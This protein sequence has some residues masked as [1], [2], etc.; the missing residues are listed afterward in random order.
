MS[1]GKP[2]SRDWRAQP[3]AQSL[4]AREWRGAK[5]E[6]A[7]RFSRKFKLR[8]VGL[9]LVTLVAVIVYLLAPAADRVPSVQI[10]TFGIGAYGGRAN[11]QGNMPVNP[12]GE[13]DARAFGVLN[14]LDPKQFPSVR[15]GDNALNGAQFL[16][17]LQKE[18]DAPELIDQHLLVFCTLH[19]L[20][21]T[22]GDVELFA[23][24]AT[25]DSPST[26]SGT[27]VPLKEL[28][29]RLQSSRARRVLLVLDAAR[30]EA[31]WRLG[32]LNNDIAAGGGRLAS[33]KSKSRRSHGG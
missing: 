12:F 1:A 3:P 18:A 25:P 29:T 10:V 28:V 23:I 31:H 4:Y 11:P 19:G 33:T 20:V 13:Q 32:I 14:E 8:V 2:P 15:Q 24:D 21:Q 7:S 22:S 5:G 9:A 6:T 16:D 17:F 30:L 27:M 26:S